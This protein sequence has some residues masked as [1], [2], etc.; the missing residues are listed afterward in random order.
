LLVFGF[1]QFWHLLFVLDKEEMTSL[2]Q[3]LLKIYL[4]QSRKGKGEKNDNR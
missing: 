2:E 4:T 1:L 3:W